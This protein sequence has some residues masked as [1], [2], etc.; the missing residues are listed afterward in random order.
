MKKKKTFL[1]SVVEWKQQQQKTDT[2]LHLNNNLTHNM[3]EVEG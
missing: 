1:I 2:P 3:H